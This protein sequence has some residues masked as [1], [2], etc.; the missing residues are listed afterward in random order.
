MSRTARF[1]RQVALERAIALFWSRGYYASSL[2]HIEAALDMRPGSLYAT[3][4]SK[5]GLFTEALEAYAARTSN[6]FHQI[7]EGAPTPIEGLKRYLRSFVKPCS[8]YAQLPAKACMLIKTLLEINSEDAALRTQV[9]AMLCAIEQALCEVLEL[10]KAMNELRSNVDCPRLA[11]LIQTQIIGL[12][13][14]AERNV[15]SVQIE[16]LADDMASML[17]AYR[18]G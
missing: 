16:A 15:P 13:A 4:G 10:A 8:G 12:R 14:F 6:D 7:I 2:K 5:S 18:A 3:F 9:E 1:D 17:D 11:R